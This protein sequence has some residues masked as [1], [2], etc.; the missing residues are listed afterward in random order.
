MESKM[1]YIRY[2]TVGSNKYAYEISAYWDPE[3]K[4]SRQKTVYLG[5]VDS[6]GNIISK[7]TEKC[8]SR[9]QLDFGDGYLLFTFIKTLPIY[10]ILNKI[11][12]E[13]CP[14]LL[15]LIIYRLSM[16]SSMY[17]AATWLEGNITNI[18]C[19]DV[20]LSSQ[21]TSNIL[22][23]LGQ[24]EIQREFFKHYLSIN[25]GSKF[26]VIIDATSLPNQISTPF[27]A[28]GR[29]DGSI[30]K[31]FRFLCVVD[32]INKTPLF[33]RYLPGNIVDVIS[34]QNTMAE[35]RS[36][37]VN[38]SFALIDAGYCSQSNIKMLYQQ[39][40]DF[41]TRLPASRKIYKDLLKEYGPN[42]E[43]IQNVVVYGE[44]GMFVKKVKID[45][46]GQEAFAYLI[47]D[48]VRKG[49]EMNEFI[50]TYANMQKDEEHEE[51]F[52]KC[53]IMI[54]IASKDIAAQEILSSY[55]LRQTIEQIFGF[56]K[57]DLDSLPLRRHNDMTVRGYLFL[58]F[59]VLTIFIELRK[60]L[61]GKYTVEQALL[62]LRNLK[63]KLF[64][65]HLLVAETTKIQKIIF[66]LCNILVPN[67]LGI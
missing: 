62:H 64:S 14:A 61:V 39:Q 31:Q 23:L 10:P 2:K 60:K 56:F 41:L 9:L 19:P 67:K 48:P 36:M 30:D 17:N 32:Q 63:C 34:L 33:Y 35:L 6:E 42:L 5:V 65:S 45:L 1:S 37:G 8:K 47:Q 51:F 25:N 43:D 44:R 22:H 4:Y 52:A 26:N 49:K 38:S 21:N 58:Q 66:N 13:S 11:F 53:G 40:I 57:D 55:Y 28:W 50:F 18:L 12:A 46:Y 16:Q 20:N 27:N 24:E 3:L 7:Q 59:I 29:N 15:T 54:L